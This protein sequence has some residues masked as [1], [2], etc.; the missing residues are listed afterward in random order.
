MIQDT[1]LF[2][3]EYV[4]SFDFQLIFILFLF[5]KIQFALFFNM[6]FVLNLVYRGYIHVSYICYFLELFFMLAILV[7]ELTGG[8]NGSPMCY[9]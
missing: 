4:H 9:E 6:H 2:K 7:L 8:Q 5:L 3:D 1:W